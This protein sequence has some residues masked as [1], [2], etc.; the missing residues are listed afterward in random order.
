MTLLDVIKQQDETN[1]QILQ[2]VHNFGGKETLPGFFVKKI[3]NS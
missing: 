2:L 3:F 1:A